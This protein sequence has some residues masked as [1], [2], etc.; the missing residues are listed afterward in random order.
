[1]CPKP[2]PEG[3]KVNSQG[4]QPLVRCL[5]W[6]ATDV[7]FHRDEGLFPDHRHLLIAQI[8]REEFEN[9]INC[10]N[11]TLHRKDRV[12][13]DDE[14]WLGW[15][16]IPGDPTWWTPTASLLQTYVRQ[17]GDTWTFAKFE[18]GYLYAMSVSH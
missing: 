7:Q 12:Y 14:M 17:E 4:R 13:A 3:A 18:D 9:Y 15:D 2:S 10:Q 5:P 11:I 1:M 16:V 8:S 6:L